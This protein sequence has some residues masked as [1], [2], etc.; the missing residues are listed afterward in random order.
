MQFG[1]ITELGIALADLVTDQSE[2]SQ[3]TFGTD[4][5][6]GP[7]GAL[8]HLA[9]EVAEVEAAWRDWDA[10]SG[11]GQHDPAP[12][13]SNL[14]TEFGDCLLLLLDA[15]RRAG[16]KPMQLIEAAQAKMKI[17]KTRTWPKPVDDT[18]VEHVRETP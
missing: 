15:S 12:F 3:T 18:P 13:K 5:A 1:R 11:A 9:K 10:V 14:L 7:I 6:R 8:R 2:W 17:N 16:I 4:I